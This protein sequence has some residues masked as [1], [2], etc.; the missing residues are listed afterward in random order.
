MSISMLLDGDELNESEKTEFFA[1]IERMKISM[2][3]PDT[4]TKTTGKSE[5][6]LVD[7]IKQNCR[8][9]NIRRF[10]T[11]EEQL[12]PSP[13]L[14]IIERSI[15]NCFFLVSLKPEYPGQSINPQPKKGTE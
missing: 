5:D 9:H 2:I 14:L 8:I 12:G 3:T 4:W 6:D 15:G 13:K 1:K 7:F 11:G 10:M